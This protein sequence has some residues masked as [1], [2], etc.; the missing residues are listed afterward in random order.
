MRFIKFLFIAAI[1]LVPVASGAQVF[2]GTPSSVKWLQLNSPAT[3][4]IFP[5]GLD[6]VAVDI[7]AIAR[8]L[9]R[10]GAYSLGNRQRQVPI[11]LHNLNT[12]SNGYVGLGP[13]RSEFYL[14]PLANSFRLVVSSA[15]RRSL[16]YVRA[17]SLKTL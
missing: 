2:G 15:H 11:V 10:S 4:V 12:A 14:T 6:T 8:R 16:K 9:N 17:S 7:A 5:Q 13:F 1:I 3:Q